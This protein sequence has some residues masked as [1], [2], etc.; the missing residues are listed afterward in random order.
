MT[1]QPSPPQ[2][3]QQPPGQQPPWPQQPWQPAYPPPPPVHPQATT[4]L[5]LGI[6]GLVVCQVVGPFAWTMGNRVVAEIDAAGGRLGGGSEANIGRILGI[7]STALLALSVL[8]LGLFVMFN[9][10]VLAGVAGFAGFAG[11]HRS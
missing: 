6:V 11:H 3:G 7:V 4:V 10:A 5:V 8:L 9:I 1:D 2:P